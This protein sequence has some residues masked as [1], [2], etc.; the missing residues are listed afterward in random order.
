MTIALGRLGLGLTTGLVV[1]WAL[2]LTGIMAGVVF[3]QASMPVAVFNFI[4]AE[5]FER[6]PEN[7][8]AVIL[9]STLV[10]FVTLPLLVGFAL[11]L[12][13]MS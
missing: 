6:S 3:L 7:V 5:R 12:G 11:K 9:L 8:A 2:D 13:G 4:F 1:I 10:S